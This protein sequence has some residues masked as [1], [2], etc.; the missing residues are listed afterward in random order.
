[1]ERSAPR[2]SRT[3]SIAC[4]LLA[5]V[6]GHAQAP[7]S[8]SPAT[9]QPG[10]STQSQSQPAPSHP[11]PGQS[12]SQTTS[13]AQNPPA[14]PNQAKDQSQSPSQNKDQA[15]PAAKDANTPNSNAANSNSKDRLFFALPNF[16]TVENAANV[17]PLT[18]GEKFK[19][20]GRS[21]FD[22]VQFVWYAALAGISQA[23]NS[24]PG[25]GQGAEGYGKRY[26][27]YFADGTIENFFVGAIFPS[28]LRTD[29]RFFQSSTGTFMHRTGYAISRAFVTRSD[30]GHSVFN[31]S[32]IF[33]SA[34][35]SA[36]STYSYHPHPG[37]HPGQDGPYIE[38]DRTLKNTASVWGS[39]VGYDTI[40]F[41]IKEFWPDVR[42]KLKKKQ[43]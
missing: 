19:L 30:S 1:M 16:L 33:G 12:S 9:S 29:P 22:P 2:P 35:A 27:A 20:V 18:A 21:A 38:S 41:V 24:E 25:F 32:E 39:Q 13:P 6:V 14:D 28:I 42:R 34:V 11:Q 40:T 15:N 8:Q 37:Y 3:L 23:S 36:I 5:A 7:D 26:G 43:Q 4:L 10:A 17:P 31:A